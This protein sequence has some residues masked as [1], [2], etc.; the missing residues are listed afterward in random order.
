[1][2]YRGDHSTEVSAIDMK[3]S[4]RSLSSARRLRRIDG[5]ALLAGLTQ[6]VARALVGRGQGRGLGELGEFDNTEG[7]LLRDGFEG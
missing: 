2:P 5:L 7:T 3:R 4:R 6:D 1:V